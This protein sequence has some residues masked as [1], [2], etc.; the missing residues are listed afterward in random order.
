VGVKPDHL[1][2]L[3]LV[4]GPLASG[5]IAYG[6]SGPALVPLLASRVRDGL[7]GEIAR[8]TH[9]SDRGGFNNIVSDFVFYGAIPLT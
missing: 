3:E 5:Y 2:G 4:L 1:T 8:L 9:S 6:W 7:D